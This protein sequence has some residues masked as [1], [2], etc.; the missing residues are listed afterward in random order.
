MTFSP[1]ISFWL[2]LYDSLDV[3]F[4]N[5][6]PKA[7]FLTYETGPIALAIINACKKNGIKTISMQHGI[8]AKNWK[9]YTVNPLE[10]QS[11]FGFPIP[12]KMLLYGNFSKNILLENHFPQ[13]RL[14]VFGNPEFFNLQLKKKILTQSNLRK[15]YGIKHNQKIILFI[16][17]SIICIWDL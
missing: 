14:E 8:I 9:Y 4:Q 2:N 17:F 1:Y 16:G 7:V 12:D 13:D 5:S 11:R 10:T 3:L 6:K 15:K